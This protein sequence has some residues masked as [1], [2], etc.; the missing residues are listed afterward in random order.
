[1]A[2]AFR[3]VGTY[4][5]LGTARCMAAILVYEVDHVL[6]CTAVA[7][8]IA[9]QRKGSIAAQITVAISSTNGF[10]I[11]QRAIICYSNTMMNISNRTSICLFEGLL[12]HNFTP[13]V[14]FHVTTR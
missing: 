13:S 6:S 5:S 10:L 11:Q 14:D 7:R 2:V 9:T 4:H 8:Y 3:D 1:M 12:Q